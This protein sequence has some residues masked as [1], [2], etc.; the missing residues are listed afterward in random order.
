MLSPTPLQTVAVCSAL[1][2]AKFVVTAIT[3]AGKKFNSGNR[4][5]EDEA[6]KPNLK[7]SFGIDES[8]ALL[9]DQKEAKIE[10]I[11]WQRILS[12]DVEN[13]PLGLILAWGSTVAGGNPTVTVV[14]TIAFTIARLSHTLA[15]ANG[16][17]NWRVASYGLGLFSA[18]TLAGNSIAGAFSS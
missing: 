3:G 13:I 18:L 7:Q 15:Y 12:N 14:A 4:A 8:T 11:R 6:A 17:F 9:P 16:K 2:Y 10:D 5:P 1:L